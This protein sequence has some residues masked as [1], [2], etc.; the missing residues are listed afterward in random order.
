MGRVTHT[1]SLLGNLLQRFRHKPASEATA[2]KRSTVQYTFQLRGE[3]YIATSM[4]K[5]E[6][7]FKF[8]LHLAP[9]FK[10]S[11]AKKV[12]GMKMQI[13]LQSVSRSISAICYLKWTVYQPSG[14]Q[15][16]QNAG[17]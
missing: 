15:H 2:T 6:S 12:A 17:V 7:V 5:L 9:T 4:R 13:D 1:R 16:A 11:E 8:E 14:Y 10:I 3:V